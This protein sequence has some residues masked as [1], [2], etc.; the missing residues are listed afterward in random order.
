MSAELE[1]S[2]LEEE[3]ENPIESEETKGGESQSNYSLG[4]SSSEVVEGSLD[5]T[6]EQQLP[7]NVSGT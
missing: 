4:E 1:P 3:E 6:R 7:K 5:K 2:L